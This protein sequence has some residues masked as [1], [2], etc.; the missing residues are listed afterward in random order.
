MSW[1]IPVPLS[2]R[3]L[4]QVAAAIAAAADPVDALVVSDDF[5]SGTVGAGAIGNLGW[6][7]AGGTVS[8]VAGEADHP[9]IVRRETGTTSNTVAYTCLR[10]TPTTGPVSLADAFDATWVFRLNTADANTRARLGFSVNWS[11]N[12]PTDAIYLEK[13][14]SDTAWFGVARAASTQTRSAALGTADT[15]WHR[16]RI[17]RIDAST[18]GFTLDDGAEVTVAADVPAVAAQPGTHL[19]NTTTDN[20]TLDHDL[21]T[22]AIRGLTR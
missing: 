19:V 16:L 1:G 6:Y 15:D 22:L 7:Q 11:I 9:G 20:K 17:R 12:A 21:F 3:Q 4:D 14:E 10:S 5:I 2:Q 8:H 13:L 18:V